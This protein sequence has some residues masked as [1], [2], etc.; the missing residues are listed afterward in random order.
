MTRADHDR[1]PFGETAERGVPEVGPGGHEH[2]GRRP[3]AGLGSDTPSGVHRA[4]ER[5]R[6]RGS[7]GLLAVRALERLSDLRE[8]LGLAEH[9]RIEPARDGEQVFRGVGLV[10]R[11]ERLGQIVGCDTATHTGRAST[12]GTAWYEG[13]LP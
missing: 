11:V 4:V 3:D 8:D 1:V 7:R 6:E 13:T 5:G 12:P 2:V 10:V 9:H